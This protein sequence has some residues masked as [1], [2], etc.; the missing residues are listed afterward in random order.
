MIVIELADTKFGEAMKSIGCIEKKLA[1]LKNIF[2][3]E[4]TEREDFKVANKK[5][6]S[7][8]DDD[9]EDYYEDYTSKHYK[10]P[11]GRYM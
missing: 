7:V 1:F 6:Y 2:E 8:M 10:K 9:N 3:S 11:V 5:G 4:Y